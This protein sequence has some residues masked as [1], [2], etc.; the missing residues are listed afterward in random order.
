MLSKKQIKTKFISSV[1]YITTFSIIIFSIA[2]ALDYGLLKMTFFSLNY[3]EIY[4]VAEITVPRIIKPAKATSTPEKVTKGQIREIT[5]YN[6][7][8]EQTD[9][10]PCIAAFGDNICEVDYNV[11]ATNAFPKNTKLK[12]KGLGECIVK[13]R[14]NSRYAERID[15]YAGM[16]RDR[17]VKFGLQRLEVVEI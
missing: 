2:F 8:P 1:G 13:D 11:C 17:A 16:D 3:V 14:M 15:W 6:S 12:V 7:L 5:M 4:P 9:G 10:S